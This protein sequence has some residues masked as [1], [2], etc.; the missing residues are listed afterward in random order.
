MPKFALVK[1][2]NREEWLIA[3]P[4]GRLDP[5]GSIIERAEFSTLDKA[6]SRRQLEQ[7]EKFADVVEIP[8]DAK[9]LREYLVV[10]PAS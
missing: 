7:A 1:R 10:R 2:D 4:G 9:G 3:H 5:W 8:D 6:L